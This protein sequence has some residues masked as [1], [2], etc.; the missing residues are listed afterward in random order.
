MVFSS[1]RGGKVMK[2][3]L[4]I[5][6][7]ALV[8]GFIVPVPVAVGQ[9]LCRP[10]W[11]DR[12]GKPVLG[13]LADMHAADPA[14]LAAFWLPEIERLYAAIP[15]LSPRE[16]RWLDE[17]LNAG[18]PR[19]ANSREYAI[20]KAKLNTGSLLGSLRGLT[21]VIKPK[22][23]RQP[24]KDWIFFVYVLID[25]DSAYD[26]ARLEAEGVIRREVIPEPWTILEGIF[27]GQEFP[28]RD[29]IRTGRSDLARHVLICTLPSVAGISMV[30]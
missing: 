1:K 13:R 27:E 29:A 9:G 8:L 23:P 26:L 10:Q 22:G 21:E 6:L 16:E 25:T 14:T 17:E 4:K 11:V 20:R 19:A 30:D 28:L 2:H 5:L 18:R 7:L 24:T 12:T 3:S 15:S